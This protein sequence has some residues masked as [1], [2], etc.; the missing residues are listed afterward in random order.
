[1]FRFLKSGSWCVCE[2]LKEYGGCGKLSYPKS[3]ASV[4]QSWQHVL[5]H[6]HEAKL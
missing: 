4:V 2:R 5:E 3:R 1:M 6:C